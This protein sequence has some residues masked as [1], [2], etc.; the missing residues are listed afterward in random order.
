MLKI[1]ILS[2]L[3]AIALILSFPK[4]AFATDESETVYAKQ[5]IEEIISLNEDSANEQSFADT[6]LAERAGI[7]AE[8]YAIALSESDIDMSKYELILEEKDLVEI[9]AKIK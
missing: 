4:A 2:L 7:G 9:Y 6:F 1:K 8:W 5:I 3:C